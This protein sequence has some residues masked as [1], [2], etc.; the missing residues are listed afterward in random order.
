MNPI[1]FPIHHPIQ[2]RI[3]MPTKIQSLFISYPGSMMANGQASAAYELNRGY[4]RCPASSSA[5][6]LCRSGP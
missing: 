4:Q 6:V 1:L 5:I 3:V 2:P